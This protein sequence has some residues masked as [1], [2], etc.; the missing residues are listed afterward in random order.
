[1]SDLQKLPCKECSGLCCGPVPVTEKELLAIKKF[2]KRMPA[3]YYNDLKSQQRYFGTCLFYDLDLNKCG[4]YPERP[5]IC[6]AFG[7]YRNL[8]CFKAPGAAASKDLTVKEK[9][10]GMLSTDFTWKD[11]SRQSVSGE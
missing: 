10:A 6:K 5:A 4:I 1:M 8:V 11:F 7:L 9:P 3:R 2:V